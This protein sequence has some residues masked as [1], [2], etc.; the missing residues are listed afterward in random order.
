MVAEV[1][2]V[3]CRPKAPETPT[4]AVPVNVVTARDLVKFRACSFGFDAM[5]AQARGERPSL[6]DFIVGV[7]AMERY[8]GTWARRTALDDVL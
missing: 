2:D 4:P 6:T 7:E 3:E 1:E 5:S 8:L